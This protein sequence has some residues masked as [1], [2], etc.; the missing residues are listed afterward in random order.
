[1]LRN[2]SQWAFGCAFGLRQEDCGHYEA[3]PQARGYGRWAGCPSCLW[4]KA[5]NDATAEAELQWEHRWLL[6]DREEDK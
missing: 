5:A 6:S 2:E 1:M 3:D 4:R